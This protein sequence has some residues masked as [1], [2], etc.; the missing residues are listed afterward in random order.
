VFKPF[1]L[2]KTPITYSTIIAHLKI[3]LL[4]MAYELLYIYCIGSKISIWYLLPY[5]IPSIAL[6][7]INIEAILP[8]L[9]RSRL[10]VIGL[11][12]MGIVVHAFLYYHLERWTDKALA[13]ETMFRIAFIKAVFRSF[14]ITGI[15]IAYA[16][17][18]SNM[19]KAKEVAALKIRALE[20]ENEVL[21][22]QVQPH[23]IY[24]THTL[25]YAA[26]KDTFP[27]QARALILCS[28][29]IRN[30]FSEVDKDGKIPLSREIDSILTEVELGQMLHGNRLNV[31]L[32]IQVPPDEMETKIPVAVLSGFVLDLFKHG[33]LSNPLHPATMDLSVTGSRLQF[34][35]HNLKKSVQE[36]IGLKI[37]LNNIKKR[38]EHIYQNNFDLRISETDTEYTLDLNIKL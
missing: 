15:S 24:N 32:N 4:F 33:D 16:L 1:I 30:S 7:Y 27:E 36:H 8:R 13:M 20:Y 38:L 29:L 31:L 22:A 25:V 12:L 17:V 3:I 19:E 2:M 35:L 11:L 14:Y 28:R 6:F 26:V 21:R 23:Q 34:N 37:G 9:N 10:S 18:L 5:Y